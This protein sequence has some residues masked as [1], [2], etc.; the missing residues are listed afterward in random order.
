M[1]VTDRYSPRVRQYSVVLVRDDTGYAELFFFGAQRYYLRRLQ[2]G[3]DVLVT[4]RVKPGRSAAKTVSEANISPLDEESLAH[5]M[6]ILPV[7]SL[8]ESLT[9]QQLR[10]AENKPWTWRPSGDCRKRC[11][12]L[13]WRVTISRIG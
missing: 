4:G 3:M 6:G 10:S 13:S 1:N 2:P 12:G 5:A 8:T 7:Y 11:P 9:Q